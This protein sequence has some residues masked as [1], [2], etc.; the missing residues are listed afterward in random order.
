MCF[1]WRKLR[2]PH[3]GSSE[4]LRLPARGTGE[5]REVARATWIKSLN[6][7]FVRY[8]LKGGGRLSD[9]QRIWAKIF[10][11]WFPGWFINPVLGPAL[12]AA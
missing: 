8:L 1:S 2:I 9:G 11:M 7:Y 6:G 10:T 3:V 12:K 4:E 5:S